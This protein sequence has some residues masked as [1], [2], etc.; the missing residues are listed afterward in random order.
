M[1]AFTTCLWFDTQGEEAAKFYTAIFPN[2]SV[3]K[4]TPYPTGERA[5]QTMTVDFELN[6]S[7]FVALNGGPNFTFNE[8][9]SFMVPC[10]DQAEVDHY[11]TS[12]TEGGGEES[13]CGWLRDR[14]GVSWQVVPA[15]LEEMLSSLDPARAERVSQALFQMRKIVIADL[16]AAAAR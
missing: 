10:Q 13:M 16:E 11:W 1:D 8:S 15:G 9:I 14:F 7:K 4:V 2:S 5:G 3:E 6:G 12:L